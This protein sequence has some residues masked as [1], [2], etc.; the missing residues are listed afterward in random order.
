VKW[1]EERQWG[2]VKR[3]EAIGKREVGMKRREWIPA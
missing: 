1:R 2:I 3:Q